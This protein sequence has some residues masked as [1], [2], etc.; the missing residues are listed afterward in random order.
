[1]KKKRKIRRNPKQKRNMYFNKDTQAS[2]VEF[3]QLES[4]PEREKLYNEKIH[5]AFEKLAESLIFVYGFRAGSNQIENIKTDCVSFLYET[6]HKWDESRGTKAFSYFNVVAKNWLIINSRQHRKNVMRNV[7]LSDMASMSKKDK[8]S[9]AYSQVV[10]SPDK[11]IIN[12][13][14]RNEIVKVLEIIQARVTKENEKLC[15]NAIIEVFDKI[16]QLDFLNKRA[17]YVYV[18][19]ISGLTPKKLSVAMSSIRK[20]YRDIVHDKRIIDI[21]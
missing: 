16:D 12:A 9:I 14:R 6:I 15:I 21:F 5:P 13:N 3:Q 18:R 20:H 8:H 1:L 19:E 4:E 11:I 7:S 17:I 2:I 10:E